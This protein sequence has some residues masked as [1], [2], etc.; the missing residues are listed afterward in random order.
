MGTKGGV[1]VVVF[2]SW[3][4]EAVFSKQSLSN[5]TQPPL[6]SDDNNLKREPRS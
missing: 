4:R 1:V 5:R 6:P 3:V 2:N